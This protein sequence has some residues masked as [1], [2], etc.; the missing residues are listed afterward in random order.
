MPERVIEAVERIGARFR[1]GRIRSPWVILA[2]EVESFA[3]TDEV[4]VPGTDV[5]D[6]RIDGARRWMYVAGFHFPTWDEVETEL[7][8][9]GQKTAPLDYLERLEE[10][11]RGAAG[12]AIYAP[13]L[14]AS[15]ARTKTEGRSFIPGTRGLLAD[16]AGEE[17][18]RDEMRELWETLRGLGLKTDLEEL[19]RAKQWKEWYRKM[20]G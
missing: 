2:K 5:R 18:I 14:Q 7:F 13:L 16:Y 20:P 11:T 10:T 1:Q 12:R 9:P 3:E 4:R 8:G 15:I 17:W 6:R 19:A